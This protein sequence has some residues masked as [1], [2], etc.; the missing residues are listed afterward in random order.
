MSE[1][2]TYLV[3]A[4]VALKWL[5]RLDDEPFQEVAD[6]VLRDYAAGLVSLSVLAHT[7]WEIGHAL[8]RAVRRGRLTSEAADEALRRFDRWRIPSVADTNASRSRALAAALEHG[9][10][11]YDGAYLA[12][13]SYCAGHSFMPTT[14]SAASWLAACC[15]S[16][17]S[18]TTDQVPGGWYN[19]PGGHT[20]P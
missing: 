13:P 5:L 15:S 4:S 2:P 3:D 10:S 6:Q 17:G 12:P 19:A 11:F 18:K 16:S 9:C 8:T 1:T 14:A 20:L 7:P